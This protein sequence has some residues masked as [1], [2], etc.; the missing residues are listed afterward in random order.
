MACDVSSFCATVLTF[1]LDAQNIE[2]SQ[3]LAI[4]IS[5]RIQRLMRIHAQRSFKVGIITM[6]VNYLT[7]RPPANSSGIRMR[8]ITESA[9]QFYERFALYSDCIFSIKG[10]CLFISYVDIERDISEQ[11][12]LKNLDSYIQG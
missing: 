6:S 8:E 2:G 4:L 1:R 7:T 5:K 3:R 12:E 11:I 10:T 9:H